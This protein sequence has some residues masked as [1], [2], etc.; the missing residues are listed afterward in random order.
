MDSSPAIQQIKDYFHQA[1]SQQFS[2]RLVLRGLGRHANPWNF[3]FNA[4]MIVWIGQSQHRNRRW[5]RSIQ[6]YCP[7]FFKQKWPKHLVKLQEQNK[8]AGDYW[9]LN[10]LLE[11]CWT[12]SISIQQCQSIIDAYLQESLT[13]LLGT[14]QISEQWIEKN[15]V[16]EVLM[17]P[18]IEAELEKAV[19]WQK[20]RTVLIRKY[21]DELLSKLSFDLAPVISN[22]EALEAQVNSLVFKRLSELLTGRH[23]FWDIALLMQQSCTSVASVLLPLL[24]SQSIALQE[25]DDVNFFVQKTTPRA[26]ATS[27]A[28][29]K[30]AKTIACIDDSPVIAEDL[31][32]I[33]E[34]QGYEVLSI[35]DP[36]KGL[37]TLIKA[38]PCF[39]FLDLVMPNTNGY[40]ICSFLRK[41]PQFKEIPIVMLTGHDGIVDRL[42]AKMV[43]STDF[44]GKPPD[45]TKVVQVVQK[46][47]KEDQVTASALE[48]PVSAKS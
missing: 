35:L 3:D 16:P 18:S 24:Q 5:I 15:D 36:I 43:G 4:G 38:Q 13:S 42:R 33:L 44:L 12:R 37:A 17:V 2:G 31:K 46:Y 23:T 7:E 45:P 32:R 47:L 41:S 9:E 11:E 30:P 34:P 39:I 1:Q 28:A 14:D 10:L 29:A 40:E 25:V 26:G 21:S 8:L 22:S 20:H 27:R 19:Q 6:Q 48:V